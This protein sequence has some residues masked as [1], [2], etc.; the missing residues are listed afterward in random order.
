MNEF[1][2]LLEQHPVSVTIVIFLLG[3]LGFLIKHFFFKRE[4]SA[5][6]IKAGGKI[7]VGGDIIVG[8]K[9]VKH[10]EIHK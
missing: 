5:P 6:Y 7:S 3:G 4:D 2:S 10:T 1:L 8:N 9:T